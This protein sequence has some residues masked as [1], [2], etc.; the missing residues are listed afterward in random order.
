MLKQ[1]YPS[2]Q[3][4]G[5]PISE[6]D[7]IQH[8]DIF[9]TKLSANSVQYKGYMRILEE[10]KAKST[11]Q[12]T[13][14][15]KLRKMPAF[16]DMESF[17]YTTLQLLIE[18]LN[19][20]YPHPLLENSSADSDED[21]SNE[22]A[23]VLVGETGLRNTMKFVEETQNMMQL[24]YKFSYKPGIKEEIFSPSKISKYSAK[25]HEICNCIR[26]GT[27]IIIIY[28]QYIDGGL[29]P[30]ALALE[31]MGFTRYGSTPNT[32]NLFETPPTDPVD[33]KMK[34]RKKDAPFHQAKYVMITGDKAFSHNNA[35]D[36]KVLTHA[37]NKDGKNIKVVLLSRAGA[38]GLDFK[39]I[40]QVHI[41]E[42]WYNMNR[43]EQIIGRAVRN[44]S[45]CKLPFIQRNVE[46]YLHG[47]ILPDKTPEE[48]VD[49]YVYR[50][51]EKKAVK[52]GEVTRVLKSIS[53]DC[54]LNIGQTNL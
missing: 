48:S 7:R 4:N 38:E 54:I 26:K 30:M 8:I 15:G 18:S 33:Y 21:D 31:S 53:V 27:G 1:P 50:Y 49:L 43:I 37:D 13:V 10:M 22:I 2:T 52:I 9:T 36:I 45:H 32:P 24:K 40:R 28:S 34:P 47:T 51:A 25:I 29:V 3:M 46:I 17:G 14:T 41:M 11:D 44:L 12:Y 42:P 23:K 35:G 19:I 39:N 20:V 6:E 16:E 5:S